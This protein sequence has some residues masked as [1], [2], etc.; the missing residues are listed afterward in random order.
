MLEL[1]KAGKPRRP[2][3]LKPRHALAVALVSSLMATSALAQSINTLKKPGPDTPFLLSAD[4]VTYDQSLETVV[5]RGSVE[6]VGQD[7]IVRA[8]TLSYDRRNDLVTASGNVQILEP[9]GEVAFADHV[10]LSGDL[11]DGAIDRLR[12]LL[13]DNSRFAAVNGE[14]TNGNITTLNKAVYSPC[15]LCA[16]DP[17]RPPLWQIKASQVTHNAE[18]RDITYKNAR[19]EMAG[20][21]VFYSPYFSQPDP[22]VDQRSGLLV[23]SGGHSSK[24]GFY[25]RD[26][27]YWS[28]DPT[29]DATLEALASQHGNPLFGAEVR[30]YF[31]AG[32]LTIKGAI[33]YTDRAEGDASDPVIGAN[34][35][36]GYYDIEG[37]FEIDDKWR[38]GIDA[39]RTTDKNF[40]RIYDYSSADILTSKLYAER[41]D[42]R[43][44]A[45]I[46]ALSF[47]DL[48]SASLTDDE[49]LVVPT[50]RMSLTGDA[51]DTFGGR[52]N[53]ESGVVNLTRDNGRDAARLDNAV[54]WERRD[55]L[56]YGLVTKWTMQGRF[57]A[58]TTRDSSLDDVDET[59]VRPF[60]QS[61]MLTSLPLVNR[62]GTSNLL[63]EPDLEFRAATNPSEK[64]IS[65]EDSLAIDFDTS[66]LFADNRYP[67]LDR[68]DGGS[69]VTY[70]V[71]FGTFGDQG[72]YTQLF[73]GESY[74]LTSLDLP[75]DSGLEDNR[76]D[77]VTR[78]E[79][80]PTDDLYVDYRSRFDKEELKARRNDLTAHYRMGRTTFTGNYAYLAGTDGSDDLEEA[81]GTLSIP[82]NQDWQ[83]IISHR[84]SLG[85]DSGPLLTS[86]AL[87]YE[88]ECFIVGI[89][90]ERTYT[91][92]EGL[93]EGTSILFRVGFKNL[94]GFGNGAE[95]DQSNSN[96]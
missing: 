39:S 44:Y 15:D 85:T 66:N 21:P 24:L 37:Q 32:P 35:P 61:A 57:D 65:N 7:R 42:D 92:R 20:I 47:Q 73:V 22:G 89:E 91:E 62:V 68:I 83:G 80:H 81:S 46:E 27:Y 33:T 75:E 8:D 95:K 18:T 67:G 28:V 11:R 77:Y 3:P 14:R 49:P 45:N 58:F 63:I 41:F 4:N 1:L 16:K 53:I 76:S 72:G 96:W 55:A 34:E 69:R 29:T 86:L 50:A 70:G 31:N 12:I 36:R 87:R 38:W 74:S 30:H 64:N 23:P 40:L 93:D 84:R 6:L 54:N 59:K 48:R 10:Q 25:A 52:W 2:L 13:S 5:A 90:A 19:L 56:G 17:T 71:K 82:L 78:L 60:A 9:T 26:Y 79:V 88:D 94:G 51:G 43:D